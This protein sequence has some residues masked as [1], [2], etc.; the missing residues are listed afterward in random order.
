MR[1]AICLHDGFYGCGTG[2][3]L[4]NWRFLQC[5][6]LYP[7]LIDE[8][9]VLPIRLVPESRE[10]N[11]TWHVKV[12]RLLMDLPAHVLPIDNG[13]EGQRRYGGLGEWRRASTAAARQIEDLA[14]DGP[15]SVISFDTPFVGLMSVLRNEHRV[16]H[17]HV[18]RS[19]ALIHD[20]SNEDRVAWE[21]A[22]Y[23]RADGRRVQ[24]GAI[25]RYMRRHLVDDY[26]VPPHALVDVFDGTSRFEWCEEPI[27]PPPGL[28]EGPFIL[29]FGRAVPY[30]GQHVLVEALGRLKQQGV[31]LP[32]AIIG[33]VSEEPS[34][35][36]ADA[37]EHRCREL[38][39]DTVIV[40]EFSPWLRDLIGHPEL[41]VVV[42]PSL[43]EP[44]GRIPM[45]CFSHPDFRG[46]LVTSQA[47]GLREL[48]VPGPVEFTCQPWNS[49]SLA[50][51][52][53][54]ALAY[55]TYEAAVARAGMRG[56][57]DYE[58]NTR[59]LIIGTRARC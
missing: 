40:R 5:L 21:R 16:H 2:A 25:S 23:E 55:S 45:E 34:T 49:A 48:M 15:L 12:R 17:V 53:E 56:S 37:L 10:H 27:A 35:P 26:G 19:T 9:Y 57:Y 28:V 44:F 50:R 59:R 14:A 11:A 29:C 24:L 58:Q 33:A 38:E 32:R 43:A 30:K 47:G 41:R 31:E 1:L 18:P 13:T 8:L 3:G 51:D 42:V 20:P 22:N 4:Q 6:S 39:L 36:Y 52:I 54:F 7:D 46:A